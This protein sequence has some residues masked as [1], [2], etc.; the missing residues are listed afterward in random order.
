MALSIRDTKTT[1]R[2]KWRY[3]DVTGKEIVENSYMNIKR[4]VAMHYRAN[5][6]EAPAEQEIIKYL[7]DNVS[8]PCFEDGAVYRNT[9]TDPPARAS[10]GLNSPKW[11][12]MLE[13]MKLLS[14]EGDRGLGD[15]VER[16][17]GPFGGDLFKRWHLR[18][19][20]K[21]CSCGDRQNTLNEEFPL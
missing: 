11:P 12:L 14:K 7:C 17:V 9:F 4:E 2:Q 10:R 18:I 8:V 13:P 5:G 6:R 16:V 19:F 21:P 1:P 3:P 15:I 20:G